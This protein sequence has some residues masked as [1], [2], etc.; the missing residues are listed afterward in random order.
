MLVY[1][2]IYMTGGVVDECNCFM[3][4]A[5]AKAIFKEWTKDQPSKDDVVLFACQPDNPA[6]DHI[7]AESYGEG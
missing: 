7:I 3:D 5:R 6:L 4:E 2:L 1:V